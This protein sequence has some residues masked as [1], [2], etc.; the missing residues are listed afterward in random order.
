MALGLLSVCH[1]WHCNSIGQQ[2]LATIK[3]SFLDLLLIPTEIVKI[4]ITRLFSLEARLTYSIKI[5]SLVTKHF[6]IEINLNDKI[7]EGT[8][9]C[10]LN[11]ITVYKDSIN[12]YWSLLQNWQELSKILNYGSTNKQPSYPTFLSLKN[13]FF[14]LVSEF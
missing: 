8:E 14:K 9:W 2:K 13:C 7:K 10:S 5:K 1:N 4:F 6:H 3:T 11:S 12:Y